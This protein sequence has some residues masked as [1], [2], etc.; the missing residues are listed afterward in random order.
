MFLERRLDV[1]ITRGAM[2]GPTMPRTKVY[3]I[4]GA[5]KQKFHRSSMLHEYDVS[6]GIKTAAH[7]QTVLDLFYV[8][9]MT[10]YDGFRFKDWRDFKATLDNTTATFQTGSTTVLQ[11]QRAHTVGVTVKRDIKKIV[12]ASVYRTRAAATALIAATV[13]NNTGLA[14]ISGHQSGDT[15]RWVG[16]F[17]VPVTFTDD[18]WVSE[19]QGHTNKLFVASGAIKLEEVLT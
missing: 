5:M 10:P 1:E 12:A 17:D 2:G 7:F 19:L 9:M 11:L 16:E 18:R 15:Y 8:V 4:N 13:D 14:T 3:A 6:H